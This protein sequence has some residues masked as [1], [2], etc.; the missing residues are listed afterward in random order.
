MT[1]GIE[2]LL[3]FYDK[4]AKDLCPRI[5]KICETT[6]NLNFIFLRNVIKRIYK[7]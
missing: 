3:L 7:L 6:I 5:V 2:N 1:F 4:T